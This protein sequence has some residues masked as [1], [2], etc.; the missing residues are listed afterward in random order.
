M[1]IFISA[2]HLFK[3]FA[4]QLKLKIDGGYALR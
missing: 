2:I 4:D 1:T 3:P